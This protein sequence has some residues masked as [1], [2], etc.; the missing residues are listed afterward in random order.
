MKPNK[1]ILFSLIVFI[2][3]FGCNAPASLATTQPYL[4]QR[5][6]PK[7]NAAL[8]TTLSPTAVPPTPVSPTPTATVRGP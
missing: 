6:L 5:H 1:L 3:V 2:L 8:N 7:Y 4:P